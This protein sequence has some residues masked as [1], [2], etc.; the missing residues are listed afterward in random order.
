M[1]FHPDKITFVLF[2]NDSVIFYGTISLHCSTTWKSIV[3]YLASEQR[4]ICVEKNNMLKWTTNT[5]SYQQSHLW[6]NTHNKQCQI[7][8][9]PSLLLTSYAWWAARSQHVHLFT[10]YRWSY[11]F[12]SSMVA[13]RPLSSP[14]ISSASVSVFSTHYRTHRS[15]SSCGPVT[16][17]CQYI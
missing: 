17:L 5:R 1:G 7:C 10:Y 9:F 4:L 12:L 8:I 3:L 14:F 16:K 11:T 15:L 2:S 6:Y 13:E